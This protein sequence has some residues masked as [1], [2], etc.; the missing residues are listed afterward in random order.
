[1]AKGRVTAAQVISRRREAEVLQAQGATICSICK[2]LSVTD[3][4][5]YLSLLNRRPSR[6]APILHGDRDG[7]K[8]ASAPSVGQVNARA[9]SDLG[10]DAEGGVDQAPRSWR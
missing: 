6:G 3:P 2:E 8:D 7:A 9:G 10:Y 4:T 5:C 1:M